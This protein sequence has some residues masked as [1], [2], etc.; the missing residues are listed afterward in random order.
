MRL[1]AEHYPTKTAAEL[2]ALLPRHPIKSIMITA[3]RAGLK[4]Q[5]ISGQKKWLERI[6]SY[7]PTFTFGRV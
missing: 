3:N 7:Q 2:A 5:V 6:R 4:K 1:L